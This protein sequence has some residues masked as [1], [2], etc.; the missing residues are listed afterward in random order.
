VFFEHITKTKI[1]P[2]NNKPRNLATSL[3]YASIQFQT[4]DSSESANVSNFSPHIIFAVSW[5]RRCVY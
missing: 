3:L 5:H 2:P 4:S 1:L